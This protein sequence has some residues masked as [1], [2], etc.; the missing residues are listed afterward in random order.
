MSAYAARQSN[1]SRTDK[2]RS[3]LRL[4]EAQA[5]LTW[6]IIMILAA[7]VGAIY[8]YQASQIA[9]VGREV[10]ELQYELD[11]VKRISA[12]LER[13]IAEA[14]S[15]DRLQEEALRLGFIR[16]DPADVDYMIIP[17]VPV[18]NTSKIEPETVVEPEP[19][20][21]IRDALWITIQSSIGA[22]EQGE[23]R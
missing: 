8:L 21:S 22:L 3:L 6:G 7:L 1:K 17:G 2:R 9:S 15:L 10:Q 13:E 23:S 20:E 4:S 14:Q 12:D 18:N 11:E 19:V 5:F 16:S